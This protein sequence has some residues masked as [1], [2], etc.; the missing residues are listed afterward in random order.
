M[1]VQPFVAA[2]SATVA[3]TDTTY[4]AAALTKRMIDKCTVFNSDTAA[5]TVTINLVVAAG[6]AGTTNIVM[7]KTL[8]AGESYQCPEVVGHYLD[9]NDFLSAKASTASVVNLRVSARQVS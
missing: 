5:R 7:V 1:A 6:T 8:L 3:A 4:V 9:P 2:Q